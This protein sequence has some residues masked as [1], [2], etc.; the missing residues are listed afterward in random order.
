M[1]RPVAQVAHEGDGIAQ[2][3]VG[4]QG[5]ETQ[6][7]RQ[8]AERITTRAGVLPRQTACDEACQVPMRLAR[9]HLSG[10]RE[11]AQ[12]DRLLCT[13]EQI[14]NSPG[15]LD[16]LDPGSAG[17]ARLIASHHPAMRNRRHRSRA[18]RPEHVLFP[19]P[20]CGTSVAE[21]VSGGSAP[22]LAFRSCR[23]LEPSSAVQRVQS[24]GRAGR[25]GV[26]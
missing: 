22:R 4:I 20:A 23:R 15:D 1:S 21:I 14:E 7:H 19:V 17:V 10:R 2:W 25:P 12:G 3:L 16:R 26:S 9:R 5:R 18:K 13:G 11:I 8:R 6:S 24:R